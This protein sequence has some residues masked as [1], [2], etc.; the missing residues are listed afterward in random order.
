MK[1]LT[2][3]VKE[4]TEKLFVPENITPDGVRV[5]AERALQRLKNDPALS[6]LIFP[7]SQSI[8]A[9]STGPQSHLL[10]KT[11]YEIML[12]E[13]IMVWEEANNKFNDQ[14]KTRSS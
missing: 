4:E 13:A 2:Q 14:L 8:V 12:T 6:G 9:L 3:L 5:R 1:L 7:L 10:S 11:S